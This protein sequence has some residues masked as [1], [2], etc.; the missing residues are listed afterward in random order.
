[1]RT[2]VYAIVFGA[3]VAILAALRPWFS[4]VPSAPLLAGLVAVHVG[5]STKARPFAALCTATAVG[6]ISDIVQ[7][8]PPGLCAFSAGVVALLFYL[9]QGRLLLRGW[10]F[11]IFLGLVGAA[12]AA[13]IM[14]LFRDWSGGGSPPAG[15][16][17]MIL[18]ASVVSALFAPLVFGVCKRIDA[19]M[20]RTERERQLVL[21]GV[22]PP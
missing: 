2:L 20:V 18:Q 12:I 4:F 15:Y 10:I 21:E 1:M 5:L 6:Y 11:T 8:T 9:V 13:S 16:A 17:T 22:L 7:G 3:F 19:K 14:A